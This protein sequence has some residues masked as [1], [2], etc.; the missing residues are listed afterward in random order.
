MILI[1]LLNNC[2]TMVLLDTLWYNVFWQ[3][4]WTILILENCLT[5]CPKTLLITLSNNIEW[6]H[7]LTKW[8]ND[9]LTT[10]PNN[11]VQ[12]H[13]STTLFNNIVWWHCPT[14][15]S[16]NYYLQHFL[17]T[18]CNNIILWH[19]PVTLMLLNVVVQWCWTCCGTMSFNNFVGQY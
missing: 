2:S 11:I 8:T 16:D 9:S 18:L 4:C 14:T 5:T 15:L 19:C 17:T 12:R 3:F 13:Y 10:L 6:R 1:M 7:Y